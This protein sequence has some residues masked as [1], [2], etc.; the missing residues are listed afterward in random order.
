MLFVPVSYLGLSALLPVFGTKLCAIAH[1]D[2][3]YNNFI[4]RIADRMPSIRTVGG[5]RY[6]VE[7]REGKEPLSL[8]FVYIG[9]LMPLE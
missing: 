3:M 7:K 8:I 9:R 1:I 5:R 6:L 2:A 4:T